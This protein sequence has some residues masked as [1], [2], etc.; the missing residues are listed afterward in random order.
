M[1]ASGISG[2]GHAVLDEGWPQLRRFPLMVSG[3]VH[4]TESLLLQSQVIAPSLV[5]ARRQIGYSQPSGRLPR[6][7]LAQGHPHS[8]SLWVAP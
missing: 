2:V 4:L 6:L 5:C 7:R 1:G 3:G 8:L